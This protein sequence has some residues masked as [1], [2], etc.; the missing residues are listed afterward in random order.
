MRELPLYAIIILL[1]VMFTCNKPARDTVQIESFRDTL[2]RYDTINHTNLRCDTVFKLDYDTIINNLSYP[3]NKYQYK[4]KDSLL[5]GV[6]IV[7]SP[8]KPSVNFDYT[9]KTFEVK[10]STVSFKSDLRGFYYGGSVIISPL[11][12]SAFVG[13]GYMNKKGNIINLSIGKDFATN[14]NLIQLGFKKRF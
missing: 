11:L 8:F 7:K 10:D 1:L 13:V 14:T 12:S 4:I 2:I 6:I 9:L 3:I 5:D